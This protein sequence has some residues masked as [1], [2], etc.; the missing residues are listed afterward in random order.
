MIKYQL[1][2]HLEHEF[3]GWF[4]D[5]ASFTSQVEK[6]LVDCPL[7]GSHQVRR[8]LTA[9]NLNSPKMRKSPE[10]IEQAPQMAN[11]MTA[12]PAADSKE[13]ISQAEA[14]GHAMTALRQ[15]HKKIQADFTNVGDKF[16]QEARKMHYGEAEAK[17]IYGT[18]TNEERE[19]LAEEG[20][21]FY[22]LPDAPNEH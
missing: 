4:S 6:Q 12:R 18:S 9:P 3:E 1:I 8:A 19:E 21:E 20:I 14:M 17:P 16:A 5:S 2:C 22:Q 15:L 7:C 11:A 13:G 10:C